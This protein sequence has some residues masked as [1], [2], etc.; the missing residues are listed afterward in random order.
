MIKSRIFLFILSYAKYSV[1]Y[2]TKYLVVH[3]K[4]RIA[5]NTIFR[6]IHVIAENGQKHWQRVHIR[7]TPSLTRVCLENTFYISLKQWGIFPPTPCIPEPAYS[8]QLP[9]G[10]LGSKAPHVDGIT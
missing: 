7:S 8:T 3:P 4:G 10:E 6:I 1:V 9:H 2:E 5:G